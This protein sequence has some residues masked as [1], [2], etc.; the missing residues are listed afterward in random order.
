[1]SYVFTILNSFH[2]VFIF[3]LYCV[4]NKLV[5]DEYKIWIQRFFR[6]KKKE[7]ALDTT[8]TTTTGI[9]ATLALSSPSTTE[10]IY[11]VKWAKEKPGTES[12]NDEYENRKLVNN[13]IY[14]SI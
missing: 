6:I 2:G 8:T 11:N 4:A 13:C 5:M 10:N 14:E 1:M 7:K 3:L 9:S 12:E